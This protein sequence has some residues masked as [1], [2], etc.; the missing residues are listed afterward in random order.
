MA[1][2]LGSALEHQSSLDKNVH[3]HVALNYPAIT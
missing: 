2:G 3:R 1:V